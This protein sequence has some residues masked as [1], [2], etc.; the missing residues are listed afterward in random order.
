L[1]DL[2]WHGEDL[3]LTVLFFQPLFAKMSESV[4]V[5]LCGQGADELHAGYPRYR[6]LPEH[7]MEIQ[8]RLKMLDCNL[9]SLNGD[10]WWSNNHQPSNHCKSLTDFLQF[11]LDH[12]QLSNFQ[13]RLVD[14]HSMAHGFEVRVP[15]LGSAH[16][17]HANRLPMDWRL[18]SSFEEKSALRKAADLTGLPKEIVRRPKLPAGRATS[19]IMIQ[20]LLEELM[21][22]VEQIATK[23]P[24][25]QQALLKQPDIAIGLGLFEAMHILD[26]GRFKRRGDVS[27]LLDEV[28]V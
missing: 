17:K 19:P 23:Y 1:P 26:E 25:Y 27:S 12:G 21:P 6:N 28:I 22:R 7:A 4:T 10:E 8:N 13:L 20:N 18:S 15:F 9:S 11:E 5:G 14:R 2:A 3:D 16:R 24:R